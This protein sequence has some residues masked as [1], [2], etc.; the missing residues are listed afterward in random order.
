MRPRHLFRAA[1][2]TGAVIC[3]VLAVLNASALAAGEFTTATLTSPTSGS[4]AVF[5]WAYEFHQNGGHGLSN[6]AVGFCDDEI[7]ADVELASQQYTL[8]TQG[9][10]GHD[11]FDGL[12]FDVTA[13][14]GSISVTFGHQHPIDPNGLLLQSHSGDG[15]QGDIIKTAPGPGP[16]PGTT[17]TAVDNNPTTT[18]AAPTTTTAA[19]PA[20]APQQA[21]VLGQ[22]LTAPV[23]AAEL[24]R[25]GSDGLL[26]VTLAGLSLI[27]AGLACARVPR[28]FRAG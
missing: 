6:L 27:L 3:G 2:A 23:Q 15:Q 16:C 21:V 18:T 1:C 14:T 7:L 19:A 5:T 20:V 28:R 12:K 17:N 22:T 8:L 9:E 4:S 26:T 25:T 24:P 13:V 11:G 10:G